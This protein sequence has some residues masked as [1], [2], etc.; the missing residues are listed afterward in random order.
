MANTQTHNKPTC[1][2]SDLVDFLQVFGIIYI[3]SYCF[4][5]YDP[6]GNLYA[7]DFL[8]GSHLCLRINS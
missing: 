5:L 7:C 1:I 4:K 2:S 8:K 3:L 6:L